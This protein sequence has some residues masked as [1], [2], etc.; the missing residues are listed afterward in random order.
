MA[1]KKK[2][3]NAAIKFRKE[4]TTICARYQKCI[5]EMAKYILSTGQNEVAINVTTLGITAL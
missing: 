4:H 3:Q 5:H 1:N 2:L